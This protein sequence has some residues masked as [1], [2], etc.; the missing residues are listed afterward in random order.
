LGVMDKTASVSIG[1]LEY[2][3]VLQM[4]EVTVALFSWRG[5][6]SK[7]YTLKFRKLYA[8]DDRKVE[9][10]VGDITDTEVVLNQ[11]DRKIAYPRSQ[12]RP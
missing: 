11:G 1:E 6:A 8:G 4:G 2:N 7:R 10:V 9:G 12:R 3:G 5:N